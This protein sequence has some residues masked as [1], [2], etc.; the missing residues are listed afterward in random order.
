MME[1]RHASRVSLDKIKIFF[2][3]LGYLCRREWDIQFLLCEALFTILL[4]ISST[5]FYSVAS[6]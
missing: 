4:G 5:L 2:S 6:A 1:E 3:V